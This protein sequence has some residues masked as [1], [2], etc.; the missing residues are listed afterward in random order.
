V[1]VLTALDMSCKVGRASHFILGDVI[2]R[3]R[4]S[5]SAILACLKIQQCLVV[6]NR[7]KG[8]ILNCLIASKT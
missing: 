6:L 2:L 4:R 1:F 8:T 5:T 7:V 3:V